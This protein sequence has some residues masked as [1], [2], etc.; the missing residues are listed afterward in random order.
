[1][2]LINQYKPML[3]SDMDLENPKEEEI[4]KTIFAKDN[5]KIPAFLNSES[6]EIRVGFSKLGSNNLL[7]SLVDLEDFEDEDITIIAKVLSRKNAEKKLVVV[8]DVLKDL[9]SLGRGIRRKMGKENIEGLANIESDES[10]INLEVL[11][12]YQ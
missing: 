6:L 4:F 7:Y 9:L 2:D 11:A 5:T 10:V 8:F 3:T 1:M 12:I